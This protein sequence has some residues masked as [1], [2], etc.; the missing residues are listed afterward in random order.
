MPEPI[1]WRDFVATLS[2]MQPHP[3]DGFT[4]VAVPRPNCPR[5]VQVCGT[6]RYHHDGSNMF[7]QLKPPKPDDAEPSHCIDATTAPW[8]GHVRT[9]PVQSPPGWSL[10]MGRPLFWV[11]DNLILPADI[12]AY[13]LWRHRQTRTVWRARDP[14]YN[15]AKMP[16]SVWAGE[17]ATAA[18]LAYL[19]PFHARA[20]PRWSELHHDTPGAQG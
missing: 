17:E 18:T 5:T 20:Y 15:D 19:M 12:A 9:A 1:S 4:P 3:F 16:I 2:E 8:I 6:S 13:V 7:L 14:G 10:V 11:R